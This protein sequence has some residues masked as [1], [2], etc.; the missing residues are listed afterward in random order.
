MARGLAK[1]PRSGGRM[2]EAALSSPPALRTRGDIDLIE[3]L[4]NR[5]QEGGAA[6]VI[7]GEPGIGKSRAARSRPTSGRNRGMR[8]LRLCG[9]IS[10]AH[11][12]FGALQQALSPVLKQIDT[13][14]PRQRSALLSAF[15]M[16]ADAAAP[17][18]FLVGL[19]ALTLLTAVRRASPSF[20]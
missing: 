16:S 3:G 13:L 6:L 9:V 15:G 12:P 20:S 1:A 19:A 7:S 2:T 5:V 10:E 11:L 4:L 17:D 14:P 18:I 8:V